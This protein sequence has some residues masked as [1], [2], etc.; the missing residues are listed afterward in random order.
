M[1]SRLN[2][3]KVRS[4]VKSFDGIIANIASSASSC[5][6]Y[7]ARVTKVLWSW[8][9]SGAAVCE[10]AEGNVERQGACT[11]G[12]ARRRFDSRVLQRKCASYSAYTYTLQ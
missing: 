4:A 7:T 3:T 8:N 9:V 6:E 1:K 10:A 2:L 12:R 11:A 5:R